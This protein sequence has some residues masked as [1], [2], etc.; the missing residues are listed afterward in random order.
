MSDEDQVE[1][2]SED[3]EELVENT[4]EEDEFPDPSQDP[5]LVLGEEE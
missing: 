2:D 1:L 3:V 4:I 5:D